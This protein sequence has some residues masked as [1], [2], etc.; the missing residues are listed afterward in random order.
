M[1]KSKQQGSGQMGCGFMV[2][3]GIVLI[4]LLVANAAFVRVFFGVNLARIDDRFFHAAQFVLPIIM[5]AIELWIY[6][7]IVSRRKMPKRED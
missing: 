7:Q 6:D 4:I 2:A 3:C 5:I 1:S